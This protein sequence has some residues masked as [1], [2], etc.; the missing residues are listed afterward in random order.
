MEKLVITAGICGAEVT[1]EQNPFIPYTI[2]EVV[3]E[4]KSACDAG[5]SVIHLHVRWDD[6]TP[7]Q[8]K[9]RFQQAV[10]G[11]LAVCPD[12]I[13]Q[14]TTGG[15]VGMT[16]V[17]RLAAIDVSPAPE[18]ATLNCGTCNFGGDEILVN[19]ENT[20]FNFASI[21]KKRGIKP[22]LEVFDKGMID[23]ALKA[24]KKGLLIHPLHFNFVL[25]IQISATLRDLAFMAESIPSGSTWAA[26]G[27][28]RRAFEI[29]AGAIIMGGHC[30]IGFEDCL[31][32]EKG[33]LAKSNG[34]LV[35][36]LVKL[37]RFFGR[38]IATPAEARKI[39]NI[40]AT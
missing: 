38:D 37:A 24:D 5:A 4:A 22:E 21:M 34:E 2:D 17:E 35:Q 26:C 15:A 16:D 7:T 29:A 6:G 40:G 32:L 12:V 14:P 13:I 39:L 36:K 18:Y 25:G 23:T 20:I 31:Y 8:D 1:K 3:K 27:I 28:G 19:T 9:G 10:D 30:R 33:I 11:I